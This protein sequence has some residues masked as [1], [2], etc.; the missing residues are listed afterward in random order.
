MASPCETGALD[1]WAAT[2]TPHT[3]YS[4]TDRINQCE[5]TVRSEHDSSPSSNSYSSNEDREQ[6]QNHNPRKGS[7]SEYSY[8]DDTSV[9]LIYLLNSQ[10]KSI[11][12]QL[13]A[14]QLNRLVELSPEALKALITFQPVTSANS[15][16]NQ[17]QFRNSAANSPS[18][19][20]GS[21][22]SSS[23]ADKAKSALFTWGG[24]NQNSGCDV[25]VLDIS[26]VKI[27]S[28]HLLQS[29]YS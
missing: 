23:L 28:D 29:K 6:P 13:C 11:L 14:H 12:F 25:T 26:V 10:E 24:K 15:L 22:P 1:N 21:K 17:K 2:T 3:T 8:D 27:L 7:T 20:M 9:E 16:G 5:V 4:T 19:N 18:N